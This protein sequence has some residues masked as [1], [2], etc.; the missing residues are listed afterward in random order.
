MR[1]FL[2]ACI[3]AAW[4]ALSATPTAATPLGPAGRW[5]LHASGRTLV[6][7]ELKRGARPGSWTGQLER[8]TSLQLTNL[9]FAD[10]TGPIVRRKVRKG[11][12]GPEGLELLVEGQTGSDDDL[13]VLRLIEGGVAELGFKGVA[14]P[15]LLLVRAPADEKVATSWDKERLYSMD[16]DYPANARMKAIFEADQADRKDP[17]S[18]DWAAVGPRDE[19]R[20]VETRALLEG[21]KLRSGD[22]YYRAAF[23]FQHGHGADDYLLAHV[24]ASVAIARGRADATWISAAT[25]DRYLQNIGRKQIMGT[26]FMTRDGATTQEPYERALV[27]DALRAALGVPVQADQEKRRAEIEAQF[28]GARPGP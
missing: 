6:V 24:L 2:F 27:S 16:W 22:D 14:I 15:P 13:Y 7:L 1:N 9:G 3:L 28:R 23:V 5:A 19:A 25:L 20:R 12:E 17:P 18:I 21:G 26:Q 10:V 11:T 8:P 4:L